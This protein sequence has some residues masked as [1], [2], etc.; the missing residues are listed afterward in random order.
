MKGTS[1]IE[2]RKETIEN[3]KS[4]K[5]LKDCVYFNLIDQVFFVLFCFGKLFLDDG[6]RS[7]FNPKHFRDLSHHQR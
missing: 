1:V 2:K 3:F 5:F 7:H 4:T 6:T